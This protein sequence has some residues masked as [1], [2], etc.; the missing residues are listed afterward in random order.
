MLET[1]KTI[2]ELV[3]GITSEFSVSR[4]EAEGDIAAFLEQLKEMRFLK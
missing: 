2:V 4:D 1:E 3:D